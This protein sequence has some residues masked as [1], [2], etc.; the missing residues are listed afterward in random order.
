[1]AAAAV[2][3]FYGLAAYCKGKGLPV[4]YA[5]AGVF[6][7]LGLFFLY[8]L[9]DKY[10]DASRSDSAKRLQ[11]LALSTAAAAAGIGVVFLISAWKETIGPP[12][13]A[14]LG[15]ELVNRLGVG[16]H[17]DANL[18]APSSLRR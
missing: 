2:L 3:W 18:D 4:S 8:R 1:M 5:A 10:P 15:G 7:L 12:L 11:A 14:W 9:P 17:E 16:V 6:Y 13:T